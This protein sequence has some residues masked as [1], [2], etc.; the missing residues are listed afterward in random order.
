MLYWS[1]VWIAPGKISCK[2]TGSPSLNKVL[3]LNWMYKHIMLLQGKLI[4]LRRFFSVIYL[5]SN[6][7]SFN[8]RAPIYKCPWLMKINLYQFRC[9]RDCHVWAKPSS[10]DSHILSFSITPRHWRIGISPSA[11]TSFISCIKAIETSVRVGFAEV[12]I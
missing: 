1:H 12:H 11:Q 7:S 2:L 4:S 9:S 6:H 10:G 8:T 5:P 3:E